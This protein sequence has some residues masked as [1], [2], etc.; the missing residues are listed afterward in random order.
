MLPLLDPS[1][2]SSTNDI[3]LLRLWIVVVAL[4]P[5]TSQAV[6]Q[7]KSWTPPSFNTGQSEE[8]Q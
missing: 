5:S 6:A 3:R 4:Q 7:N 1:K 8:R 2:Q